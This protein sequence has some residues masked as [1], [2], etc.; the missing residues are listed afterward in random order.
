MAKHKQCNTHELSVEFDDVE[1]GNGAVYVEEFLPVGWLAIIH[2]NG[3]GRVYK[4]SV[5]E[6]VAGKGRKRVISTP[7]V[8]GSKNAT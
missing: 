7:L 5:V 1:P 3:K 6:Q 2:R 4:I 8:E